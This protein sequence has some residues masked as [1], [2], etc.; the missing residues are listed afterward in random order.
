MI[1]KE[2]TIKFK[3]ATVKITSFDDINTPTEFIISNGELETKIMFGEKQVEL[4][5]TSLQERIKSTE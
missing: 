5:I 4:L 3:K 2:T 1:S